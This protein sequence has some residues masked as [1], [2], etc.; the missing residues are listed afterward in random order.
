M[1]KEEYLKKLKE[2][3]EKCIKVM[4]EVQNKLS[5]EELKNPEFMATYNVGVLIFIESMVGKE[6]ALHYLIELINIQSKSMWDE[7]L[8]NQ[9]QQ[10][11]FDRLKEEETNGTKK[12]H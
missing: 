1:D 11:R 7:N 6:A 10:D 9:Q 5:I 4:G 3:F 8:M 2:A 12:L